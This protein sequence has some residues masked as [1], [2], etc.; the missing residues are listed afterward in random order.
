[1]VVTLFMSLNQYA[2]EFVGILSFSLKPIISTSLIFVKYLAQGISSA[3]AETKALP[4][5]VG[6]LFDLVALRYN[7]PS[8]FS[9]L[10]MP[11][12]KETGLVK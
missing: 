9:I 2:I 12:Y 5:L 4:P 6:V 3:E 1:M 11:Q 8:P 7:L 10:S